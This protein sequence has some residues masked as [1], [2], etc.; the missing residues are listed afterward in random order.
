[1]TGHASYTAFQDPPDLP[2]DSNN[3]SAR[4]SFPQQFHQTIALQ[5]RCHHVSS[6]AHRKSTSI[7]LREKWDRRQSG[8]TYGKLT[9][10]KAVKGC[11]KVYEPEPIMSYG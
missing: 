3:P 2:A 11:R 6:G 4:V 9:I 10:A 1:M 7:C 5:P 8:S